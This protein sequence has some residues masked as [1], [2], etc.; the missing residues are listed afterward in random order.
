MHSTGKVSGFLTGRFADLIK[1][2]PTNYNTTSYSP[3]NN[4]HNSLQL[5]L[6]ITTQNDSSK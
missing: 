2:L 5:P 6:D 1:T 4:P 3:K